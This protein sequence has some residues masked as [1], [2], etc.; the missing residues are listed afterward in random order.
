M[1]AFL[2]LEAE[3]NVEGAQIINAGDALWWAVTTVTTV[4]Y[5]D[6]YPITTAGRY[7]GVI[8]MFVGIS[9]AG[10]LTA[11]MASLLIRKR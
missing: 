3:A 11:S 10:S 6:V 5:D 1:S 7:V 4:G 8:T 9:V 2:V